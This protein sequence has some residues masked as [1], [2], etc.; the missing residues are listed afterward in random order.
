MYLTSGNLPSGELCTASVRCRPCGREYPGTADSNI[1]G[2]APVSLWL[3]LLVYCSIWNI[4]VFIDLRLFR[5]LAAS[6][7]CF[8]TSTLLEA[9]TNWKRHRIWNRSSGVTINNAS[10]AWE[11]ALWLF[12]DLTIDTDDSVPSGSCAVWQQI[13]SMATSLTHRAARG[14]SLICG[15]FYGHRI[16]L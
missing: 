4:L 13:Y 8:D 3:G 15:S 2:L 5:L 1:L 12:G 14:V 11:V 7:G 16:T 6:L 10:T 9:S